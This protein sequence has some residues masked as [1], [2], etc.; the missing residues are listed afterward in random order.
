MKVDKIVLIVMDSVGIG[1]L[2]DAHK[3]GDIGSN[4]L[5]N[6]GKSVGGLKLPNLGKLG[7]GN[8][9][10]IM[11]VPP[12][13]NPVGS[14]GKMAERSPGKDTTTGHWE[15]AGIVLDTPF[16]TYPYGF[17]EE[18]ISAFEKAVGKKA[19]GNKAASGT[20]I[21]KEL[22]EEHM[23]TGNLIVYTSA[24]SVFQIAAHEEIVPV[25]ELYNI[26]KKARSLLT[27]KH[28]LSRVIARPFIGKPG[29]FQ[30]TPRRHDYSVKPFGDTILDLLI[31]KGLK[32]YGVGK[33]WDIFSGQGVSETISTVSN[34]DGVNKTLNFMKT[35][36][37]G[38]IFTNLVDFD[39][40]YGHRNNFEGYASSLQEFDGRIPDI[41]D[42]LGER[43][44]IMIT[45]D[46][47]CDPTTPGTDHTREYIP[48][49]VYGKMV[50]SG[51]NLGVR[52]SFADIAATVGDLFETEPSPN[53]ISFKKEIIYG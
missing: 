4:T 6:I 7:L 50:K 8:I 41:M 22:G 25:E 19:I 15:I 31:K 14:Y 24:D 38:L 46:H 29:S 43:D 42:A 9:A 18:V 40:L 36:S 44:I 17:P 21:I 33:I 48:L 26:C 16:P 10:E 27:G 1:E 13:D 32:V 37:E 28:C 45:A 30:R 11:G 2:P 51:V 52:T 3:Y 35:V 20:E 12:S 49:L 34:Q 5:A 23:K 39:M 47:G 53:G